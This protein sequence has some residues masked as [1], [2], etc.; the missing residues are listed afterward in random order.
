MM[1]YYYCHYVTLHGKKESIH[2]CQTKHMSPVKLKSFPASK[3]E[4]VR[5]LKHERDSAQGFPLP[6]NYKQSQTLRANLD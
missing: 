6:R 4:E 3:E 5:D 2:M 1:K